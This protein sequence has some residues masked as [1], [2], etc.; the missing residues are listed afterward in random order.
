MQLGQFA[1]FGVDRVAVRRPSWNDILMCDDRARAQMVLVA[2]LVASCGGSA[3][4]VAP[5]LHAVPPPS[6]PI[7]PTNPA[8]PSRPTVIA[9]PAVTKTVVMR[10]VPSQNPLFSTDGAHVALM[11]GAGSPPR[12]LSID[13][14]LVTNGVQVEA[15][16]LAADASWVSYR[17]YHDQAHELVHRGAR[18]PLAN[19]GPLAVSSDGTHWAVATYDTVTGKDRVVLDGTEVFVGHTPSQLTLSAAGQLAFVALVHPLR[20][21]NR[22]HVVGGKPGP[23]VDGVSELRFTSGGVQYVALRGAA[24]SLDTLTTRGRAYESVTDGVDMLAGGAAFYAARRKTRGANDAAVVVI[25]AREHGP[26]RQVYERAHHG[27]HAA[28]IAERSRRPGRGPSHELVVVL[29]GVVVHSRDLGVLSPMGDRGPD[30]AGLALHPGGTE[31]AFGLAGR[32]GRGFELVVVAP[33]TP[34]VMT[35]LAGEPFAYDA[36]GDRVA[37]LA[38]TDNGKRRVRIA[39]RPFSTAS[40]GPALDKVFVETL[41]FDAGGGVV[42]YF[43]IDGKDLVRVEHRSL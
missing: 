17:T 7:T 40:D 31:L 14:Q 16:A 15:V 9:A 34:E 11:V 19:A 28:W 37:L 4:P 38:W 25:G 42:T 35:G 39:A 5:P 21:Q 33:G 2:A 3:R 13:G 36:A 20:G 27:A 32:D 43:A 41:R 22:V 6:A 26:Y 8:V 10:D 18:I 24:E 29:D 23:V 30:A 12:E 1:A